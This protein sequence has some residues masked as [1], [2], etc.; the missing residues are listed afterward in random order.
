MSLSRLPQ[1]ALR[2]LVPALA[3]V[4]KS[5]DDD[6]LKKILD[7]QQQQQ[8]Q[9]L[10]ASAVSKGSLPAK[11]EFAGITSAT[12]GIIAALAK[13]GAASTSPV[14]SRLLTN[15]SGSQG[16]LSSQDLA[17]LR[18]ASSDSSSVLSGSSSLLT[19][20][21]PASPGN[22]LG[23]VDYES[24]TGG[25]LDTAASIDALVSALQGTAAISTAAAAAAS[26]SATSAS[27]RT[28]SSGRRSTAKKA[29]QPQHVAALEEHSQI[30]AEASPS[31]HDDFD[32]ESDSDGPSS[33]SAE[34]SAVE[35]RKEQNR[36][37]Q[38][39]FRQKDKVRQKEV[40]WRASQYEELVA[41]NKR[42]K[43]D[44]DSVT[45]E[46]D[47]YRSILERNGISIGNDDATKP[48]SALLA[49]ASG[50]NAITANITRTPSLASTVTAA[51]TPV[52][53]PAQ[54]HSVGG[55]EQIAQDTFGS[56]PAL[57]TIN[58]AVLPLLSLFG[59]SFA[60]GAVK[61]DPMFGVCGIPSTAQASSSVASALAGIPVAVA[62]SATLNSALPEQAN[63]AGG[64][65][66][67]LPANSD[68]DNAINAL[69]AAMQG[70]PSTTAVTSS[71]AAAVSSSNGLWFGSGM[72][73]AS[74]S[75][76]LL[77]ESPL[78]VDQHS[79]DTQYGGPYS[80]I[81]GQFVDP[82]SFIDELLSSPDYSPSMGPSSSLPPISSGNA[83]SLSR[84]R[85]YDDAMF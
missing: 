77:I 48:A 53:S 73:P 10:N 11:S 59:G 26:P 56:L 30:D 57:S 69:T 5:L 52:L 35:R 68:L 29:N 72:S 25:A 55:M 39:K 79:I 2:R 24:E 85:S 43:R 82:M 37:A 19:T 33:I 60:G 22:E 70:T 20:P 38:K 36:R 75:D 84:K 28:S 65:G 64:N 58:P 14:L 54:C 6:Q 27:R 18:A 67:A 44:I 50:A 17:L 40:K 42:F 83:F 66:A 1:V 51:T 4:P 74:S 80:T 45:R 23:M 78:M 46:R 3:A 21:E 15:L 61:A 7:P 47:M 81:D 62:S 32:K 49:S 9:Q 13:S 16:N 34:L 76:P 8:L 31:I 63:N 12:Q 41:S 71:T